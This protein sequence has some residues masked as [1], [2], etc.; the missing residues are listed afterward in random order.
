MRSKCA[1]Q[2]G[3]PGLPGLGLKV[4]TSVPHLVLEDLKWVFKLCCRDWREMST[5]FLQV[6]IPL[7]RP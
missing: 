6:P 3:F 2:L 5:K 4:F 1:L 7:A